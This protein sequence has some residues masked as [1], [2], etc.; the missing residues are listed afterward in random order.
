M[1]VSGT[2][3]LWEDTASSSV[4]KPKTPSINTNQNHINQNKTSVTN[5]RR[6]KVFTSKKG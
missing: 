6:P 5:S 3:S 1:T 4:V 2:T